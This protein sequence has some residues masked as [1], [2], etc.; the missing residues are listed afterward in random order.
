M[1]F[2]KGNFHPAF[3][4]IREGKKLLPCLLFL[5]S[6]QLKRNIWRLYEPI[7]FKPNSSYI[8]KGVDVES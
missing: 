7:L 3:R 5:N 4:Q 8:L 1:I 2:Q 6:F